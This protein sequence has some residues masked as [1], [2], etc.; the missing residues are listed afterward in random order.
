MNRVSF[1]I[2][3]YLFTSTLNAS[4]FPLKKL[5]ILE[6]HHDDIVSLSAFEANDG[7]PRASSLDHQGTVIFWDL[8]SRRSIWTKNIPELATSPTGTITASPDHRLIAISGMGSQVRVLNATT[9]AIIHVLKAETMFF[10]YVTD[11]AFSN[12]SRLLAA[13]DFLGLTTIFETQTGRKLYT[14]NVPGGLNQTI[15]FGRDNSYLIIQSESGIVFVRLAGDTVVGGWIG[16]EQETPWLSALSPDQRFIAVQ[17]SKADDPSVRIISLESKRELRRF[18]IP[19]LDNGHPISL[20]LQDRSLFVWSIGIVSPYPTFLDE[21]DV[22]TGSVKG[23]Y[24][25]SGW[26]DEVDSQKK[27]HKFMM[28]FHAKNRLMLTVNQ[29]QPTIQV[30]SWDYSS[31]GQ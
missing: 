8:K 27:Y 1:S 29:H 17:S 3:L 15:A 10:G 5:G 24:Q 4:T 6:G 9:G 13:V 25:G 11:L 23:T 18:A 14:I 12:D 30:W 16:P 20:Y 2:I 19:S 7:S 28:A 31:D 26:I 22:L 21:I